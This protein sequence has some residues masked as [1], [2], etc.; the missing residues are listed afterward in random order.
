MKF[1]NRFTKG[2]AK[3]AVAVAGFV[4]FNVASITMMIAANVQHCMR[5]GAVRREY[6][7]HGEAPPAA[8]YTHIPVTGGFWTTAPRVHTIPAIISTDP[9]SM[10]R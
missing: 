9:T 7:D 6:Y 3:E 4:M 1:F 10:S 8:R 2:T 5:Q